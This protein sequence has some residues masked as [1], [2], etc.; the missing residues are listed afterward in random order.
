MQYDLGLSGLGILVAL[1]LGFG[2]I[3]HLIAGR[4]TTWMWA[5][6]ALAAFLGGLYFS[7]V[8]FATYTED[9]I[10]PIID[11]L[12]LDES[13][14]GGLLVGSAAVLVTWFLTQRRTHGPIAH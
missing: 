3:A 13:M 7:E 2:V 10:Q 8:L 4:H 12:A 9:E 6:G 14:L 11:G 1:A 5:V